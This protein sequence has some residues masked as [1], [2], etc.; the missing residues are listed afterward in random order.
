MAR[1]DPW[2]VLLILIA[3][4]LDR[5]LVAFKWAW[6]LRGRGVY[7]PLIRS[8]KIYCAAMI[9]GMFLPA[10]VGADAIRACSASQ[11]GLDTNKVVSSIIIERMIGFLSA[12]LLGLL[13]LMLLSQLGSLD[14][15]FK[16]VWWLG[17]VM[18]VGSMAVFTASFTQGAFDF[19][20]GYLLYRFRDTRLMRRLRQFHLTY[21]TY[22][23]NKGNLVQFFGLTFGEQLFA[24]PQIWLIARG[25]GV[26]VGLLYIAG[27]FPLVFLIAQLPI[28]IDG[29]GVFDGAFIL[30]MSLAGVSAAEAVAIAFVGRILQTASWLPWWLA[31][32]V[33]SRSLRPRIPMVNF[34]P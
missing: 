23:D 15:R 18:I 13:S 10:T 21:R 8:M 14:A 3:N 19:L 12:L 29:L 1:I 22:Q 32:V 33:S 6:L 24:I 31:H 4:T 5:G 34:Q 2:Y 17:S 25:L 28:S 16:A 26:D 20:H 9:W 11:F 30:L 7:L 27:V